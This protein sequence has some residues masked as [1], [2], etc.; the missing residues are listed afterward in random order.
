M[1]R[2]T[3][4]EKLHKRMNKCHWGVYCNIEN[5]LAELFEDDDDFNPNITIPGVKKIRNLGTI[6]GHSKSIKEN[7]QKPPPNHVILYKSIL[8]DEIERIM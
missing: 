3:I 2:L 6:F 1:E 7:K 8:L 5:N 4:K